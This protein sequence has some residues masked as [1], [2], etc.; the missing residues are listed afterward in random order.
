MKTLQASAET[1]LGGKKWGLTKAP[2]ENGRGNPLAMLAKLE[3][4]PLW[5]LKN[6][7]KGFSF[8]LQKIR[9]HLLHKGR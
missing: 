8:G 1:P 6:E 7:K 5:G 4:K 2:F 3:K 9:R